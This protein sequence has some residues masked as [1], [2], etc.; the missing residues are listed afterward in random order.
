MR[1]K[2]SSL[3]NVDGIAEVKREAPIIIIVFLCT[4][5]FPPLF[6]FIAVCLFSL[7]LLITVSVRARNAE[8]QISH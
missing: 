2:A 7:T 3:K 5:N 6:F 8:A 1:K 4:V